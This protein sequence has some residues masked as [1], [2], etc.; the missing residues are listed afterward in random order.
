MKCPSCGNEN[1][2]SA[3]FC[4]ACGTALNA[5]AQPPAPRQE[6][7]QQ[8]VYSMPVQQP[9]PKKKKTGCAIAAGIVGGIVAG[10][11]IAVIILLAIFGS[12]TFNG[13]NGDSSNGGSSESAQQNN[14]KTQQ[15]SGDLMK[16]HVEIK[17]A[18]LMK[19][20]LGESSIAITYGF[21]NNS[22]NAQSFTVAITDKVFQDGVELPS[23][24]APSSSNIDW[25]AQYNDVRP[26]VSTDVTILYKLSNS[27]S[28]VEVELT[29]L[30]D[31]SDAK[32]VKV[33]T[34]Q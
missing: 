8:P 28:Q 16:C 7:P 14:N 12:D 33:F 22:D 1:N 23:T 9:A 3:A 15:G 20:Y 26:G 30:F 18:K 25:N 21:T 24:M 31:L 2:E 27:T 34:L 19:N 5:N 29:G 4:S 32:V 11:L 13:S 6:F 10:I 17:D